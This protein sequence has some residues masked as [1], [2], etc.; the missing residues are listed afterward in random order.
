MGG[1]VDASGNITLDVTGRTGMA[2]FFNVSLGEQL[3]NQGS[4][5]TSGNSNNGNFDLNG[6]ALAGDGSAV[7]VSSSNVANWG[8]FAG[9]PYTEVFSVNFACVSGCSVTPP[10]VP[11]PAAVWLFGSGLVGLAGIARRKKQA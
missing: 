3:W 11:V 9:T 10:A 2:Q 7:L 5:F 8:F 6:T 1:S 4:N